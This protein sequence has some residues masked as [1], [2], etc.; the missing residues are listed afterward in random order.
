VQISD[1]RKE[2]P[3]EIHQRESQNNLW[4]WKLS[5][6]P[7]VSLS[8][9]ILQNARSVQAKLVHWILVS[10]KRSISTLRSVNV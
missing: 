2:M 9:A 5:L 7:Y 4:L 10:R 8:N 1:F 6:I 3:V